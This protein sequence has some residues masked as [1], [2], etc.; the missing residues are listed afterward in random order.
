MIDKVKGYVDDAVDFAAPYAAAFGDN[1]A[2]AAKFA[3]KYVAKNARRR[4]KAAKRY[5]FITK[6]KNV[7]D[8]VSSA[9]LLA[10][11]ALALVSAIRLKLDGKSTE[12]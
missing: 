10:A 6:L 12:N 8:F 11:A 3:K 1:T 4:I 9:L 5:R 7:F 2:K